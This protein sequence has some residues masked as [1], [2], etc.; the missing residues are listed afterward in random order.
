MAEELA[1]D[2]V[3]YLAQAIP[4]DF[5]QI[6]YVDSVFLFPEQGNFRIRIDNEL[7]LVTEVDAGENAFTVTR[8]I[9]ETTPTTHEIDA[10]VSQVLTV[11]GL[12]A[13]IL[14]VMGE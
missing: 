8:G 5:E 14:R 13:F 7:M 9:E 12:R 11:E 2:A 1:N 3:S 6:I 4:N 10:F